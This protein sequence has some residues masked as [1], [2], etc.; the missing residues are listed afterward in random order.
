[1]EDHSREELFRS[2]A[3][4]E[5]PLTP[6]A[7]DM[8]SA[9]IERASTTPIGDVGAGES[10]HGA[11]LPGI[12]AQR[13]E[14]PP[15]GGVQLPPVESDILLDV[16]PISTVSADARGRMAIEPD[17]PSLQAWPRVDREAAEHLTSW[18]NESGSGR[19]AIEQAVSWGE[20]KF[21]RLS[22]EYD[23]RLERSGYDRSAPDVQTCDRELRSLH[24][25]IQHAN[26][27]L[28]DHPD[29][30]GSAAFYVGPPPAEGPY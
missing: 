18:V 29:R 8:I 6:R 24:G 25:A 22:A 10:D 13:P 9:A 15:R 26:D 20:R 16:L 3:F 1:M 23:E 14:A 19:N 21:E 28:A 30:H 5:A 4:W 12:L 2:D 17:T 27:I 11:S 7:S